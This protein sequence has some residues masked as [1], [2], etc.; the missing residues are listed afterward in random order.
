MLDILP[1]YF[2][3]EK[4]LGTIVISVTASSAQRGKCSSERWVACPQMHRLPGGPHLAC[5]LGSLQM[6]GDRCA[7]QTLWSR[8]YMLM[9]STLPSRTCVQAVAQPG[10][11][12][13]RPLVDLTPSTAR[14]PDGDK[15][16]LVALLVKHYMPASNRCDY[17]F[18]CMKN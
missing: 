7:L 18:A 9:P 3:N 5:L 16:I 10:R 14:F 4:T 13:D 15:S 11:L 17:F 6:A 8:G 1:C 2:L 12:L